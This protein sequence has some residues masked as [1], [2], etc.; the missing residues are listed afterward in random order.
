[1]ARVAGVKDGTDDW[2]KGRALVHGLGEKIS[3]GYSRWQDEKEYEDISDYAILFRED[4]EKAGGRFERMNKQ[5][6]GFVFRL[7]SLR[8]TFCVKQGWSVTTVVGV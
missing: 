5:P 1:M 6:F 3:Y 2:E 7:G 8:F 4:I